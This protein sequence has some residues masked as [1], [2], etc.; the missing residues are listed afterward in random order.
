MKAIELKMA[1]W[2]D[3]VTVHC[4][5]C[6][7]EYPVIPRRMDHCP[8]PLYCDSGYKGGKAIRCERDIAHLGYCTG[9]NKAGSWFQ[10]L[11]PK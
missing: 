11:K 9:R 1:G 5:W 7:T 6:N 2:D 10:W 4:S 3:G 8:H